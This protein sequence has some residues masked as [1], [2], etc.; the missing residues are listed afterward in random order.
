MSKTDNNRFLVLSL[1]RD[2]VY[3]TFPKFGLDYVKHESLPAED[4]VWPKHFLEMI[5]YGPFMMKD[6]GHVRILAVF[7]LA[8]T[9]ASDE[10]IE[11]D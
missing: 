1:D 7:L 11:S 3:V 8:Y 9:L 10:M 6:P 4:L 2:E 5:E